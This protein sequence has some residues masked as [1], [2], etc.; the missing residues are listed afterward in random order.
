MGML[1]S[2]H[3]KGCAPA[4][5]KAVSN[6]L[7][8]LGYTVLHVSE[9]RTSMCCD[10]C[11]AVM[12]KTRGHSIRHWRCPNDNGRQHGAQRRDGVQRHP[13][14]QN[15]DVFAARSMIRIMLSLLVFGRRPEHLTRSASTKKRAANDASSKKKKRSKRDSECIAFVFVFFNSFHSEKRAAADDKSKKSKTS[16]DGECVRCLYCNLILRVAG[17]VISATAAAPRSKRSKRQSECVR[18]MFV[19]EMNRACSR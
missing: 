3:V 14:E 16:A 1:K 7:H 18:C 15:K 10:L 8:H 17:D 13:A 2:K 19:L 6:V 11:G 12:I 5:T 4:P 9:Y